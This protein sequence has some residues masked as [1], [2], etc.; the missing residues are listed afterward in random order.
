MKESVEVDHLMVPLEKKALI[1][2]LRQ[3][4]VNG[5]DFTATTQKYSTDPSIRSN[6]GYYGWISAGQFPYEWEEGVYNTP[7]GEISDVI[8]TRYGHHLAKVETDA[9]IPEKCMPATFSL[10]YPNERTDEAN[11]AVKR[12]IDSIYGAL[13]AGAD[14]ADVAKRLSDCPSGAQGGDLGWFGTH[15]MVPEF[16][17]CQ[18][19]SGRWRYPNRSP[20]SSDGT[21]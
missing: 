12:R 6:N 5:A 3:A 18:L 9:P 8:T 1:D 15:R 16:R 14:F 7:V 17:S 2:S 20:P 11:A 4:L 19:C 13:Q 10:T 21:L